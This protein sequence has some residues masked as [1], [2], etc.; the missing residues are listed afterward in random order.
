MKLRIL[1]GAAAKKKSWG[2][3]AGRGKGK[4]HVYTF[5]DKRNCCLHLLHRSLA[6]KTNRKDLHKHSKH[7][8]KVESAIKN[9]PYLCSIF[10]RRKS[11]ISF[12]FYSER[13]GILAKE[14]E[15]KLASQQRPSFL[16][17][18]SNKSRNCWCF[19]YSK[20]NINVLVAEY[21]FRNYMTLLDF[22]AQLYLA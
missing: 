5:D 6:C 18:P 16:I 17:I 8:L 10:S 20:S 3:R 11:L 19:V 7:I 9:F 21:H 2:R 13:K 22:Q 4:F 1:L 14:R 15:K 12:A